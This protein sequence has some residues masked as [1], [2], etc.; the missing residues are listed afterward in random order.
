M[1]Q[2]TNEK[3]ETANN[4]VLSAHQNIITCAKNTLT[5]ER[6]KTRDARPLSVEALSVFADAIEEEIEQDGYKYALPIQ[7]DLFTGLR[8]SI[9]VHYVDNWR[10]EGKNGYQINVP[11]QT[12]CT[13]EPDG[14]YKCH[15]DK[16][17]GED[18][19]LK[20]K[21]G[22][23]EQRTTPV[24]KTWMDFHKGEKRKTNL[25]KR[26]DEWFAINDNW[27]FKRSSHV[28]ALYKIAV[29][30]HDKLTELHQ[31][32]SKNPRRVP[33]YSSKRKTPDIQYHDLRATWCTQCL[34]SGVNTTTVQDWGGWA[35]TDMI[36]HYRG[37]VGDPSGTEID[38]LQGD[39]DQVTAPGSADMLSAIQD[40]D[41]TDEQMAQIINNI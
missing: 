14:C 37:F 32:E 22:Q 8:K 2:T 19:I 26:L 3:Y 4:T 41:L 9:N 38:K 24:P 21:T 16:S 29:R 10:E 25:N 28:R 23:S 1:T 11:K 7:L 27:A 15:L 30:R 34:R 13:I 12:Q 31:G 18:G 40:A 5:V 33:G 39:S 36:D 35:N 20:P 6:Q 17:R